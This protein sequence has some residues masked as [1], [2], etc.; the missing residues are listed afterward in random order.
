VENSSSPDQ[1]VERVEKARG[2]AKENETE[3]GNTEASSSPNSVVRKGM[4]K[5]VEGKGIKRGEDTVL[6]RSKKKAL[7]YYCGGAFCVHILVFR[8][9][10]K[11]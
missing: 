10:G 9:L 6:E 3:R 2:P 11:T 8:A 1:H 7:E 4:R 5:E